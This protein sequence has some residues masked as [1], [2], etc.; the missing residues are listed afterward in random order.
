MYL[1]IKRF[2][3]YFGSLLVLIILSPVL[4][5]TSIIILTFDG[6]PI[7]FKQIRV[8]K[9]GIKFT[10]YKFCSLK[11]TKYSAEVVII[12]S[13]NILT[14]DSDIPNPLLSRKILCFIFFLNRDSFCILF[15]C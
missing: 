15:V 7:L 10:L 5:I 11:E 13:S 6:K 2:F 4:L 12:E 14:I 3:D 9:N 8:G 1:Q